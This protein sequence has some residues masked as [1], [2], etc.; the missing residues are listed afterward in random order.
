MRP[1]PGSEEWRDGHYD[2][3][4]LWASRLIP[5]VEPIHVD[6]NRPAQD[7]WSRRAARRRGASGDSP[8][9]FDDD[10]HS[11]AAE[12]SGDA[13]QPI[14]AVELD[15][16]D[17]TDDDLPPN[18]PRA[19]AEW[20]GVELSEDPVDVLIRQQTRGTKERQGGG[21]RCM[22][23]KG[24]RST[25]CGE[26][27]PVQQS[28]IPPERKMTD[29]V[30]ADEQQRLVGVGVAAPSY[31]PTETAEATSTRGADSDWDWDANEKF[32]HAGWR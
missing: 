9:L 14:E 24:R 32:V 29:D 21:S 1:M 5:D 2:G 8:R 7:K 11:S 15:S 20:A 4:G 27:P 30:V 6:A 26:S 12:E 28:P 3:G 22:D 31:T 19:F 13:I 16:C 18:H 17:E 25:H 23:T 10:G